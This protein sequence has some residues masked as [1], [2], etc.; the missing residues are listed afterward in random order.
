M[1]EVW[2]LAEPSEIPSWRSGAGSPN[3]EKNTADRRSSKCWPVW[4]RI[5]SCSR[6]N[7]GGTAAALMNCGRF[8]ITV[9]TFMEEPGAGSAA[10]LLGDAGRDRLTGAVRDGRGPRVL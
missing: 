3:S 10:Q 4:T 2:E 8:P 1:R 7:G 5:S 6:R 9:R